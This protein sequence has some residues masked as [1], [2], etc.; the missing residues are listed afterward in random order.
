MK[1][2]N[3]NQR[4]MIKIKNSESIIKNTNKILEILKCKWG[5]ERLYYR[6]S[7]RQNIWIEKWEFYIKHSNISLRS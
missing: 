2:Q 5:L 1:T 7:I 3:K 4:K 6:E